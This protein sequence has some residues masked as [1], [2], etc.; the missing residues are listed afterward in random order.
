MRFSSRSLLLSCISR[1]LLNSFFIVVYLTFQFFK[2]LGFSHDRYGKTS[3]DEHIAFVQDFH[4]AMYEREY[5]Y[6]NELTEFVDAH[7]HWRKNTISFSRRYINEG[8]RDRVVT[9][10]L[11]WGIDVPKNGILISRGRS[12]STVTTESCSGHMDISSIAL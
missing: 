9:R 4:K 3:S 12:L 10:D 7:P 6:E 11:D 1:F 5:V 8:L 2:K